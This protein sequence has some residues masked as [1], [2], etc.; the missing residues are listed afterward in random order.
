MLGIDRCIRPNKNC[1]ISLQL[2]LIDWASHDLTNKIFSQMSFCY[3]SYV[4][5][6]AI[7][8]KYSKKYPSCADFSLRNE[9]LTTI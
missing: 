7:R 6:A 1:P 5:V 3:Q 4:E 8:E 9:T 2:M